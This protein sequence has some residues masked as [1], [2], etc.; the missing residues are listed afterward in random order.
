[1]LEIFIEQIQE[2]QSIRLT[3]IFPHQVSALMKE[4]VSK[5]GQLNYLVNNGG[6]QFISPFSM[7]NKKGWSAVIDTNLNGTFHCLKEGMT[8]N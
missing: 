8:C 6:G 4:T 2:D 1:M 3:T 7:I 5:F